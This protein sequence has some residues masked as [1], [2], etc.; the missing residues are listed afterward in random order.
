MGI[1]Q[2]LDVVISLAVVMLILATVVAAASQTILT[3][4]MVRARYMMDALEGLLS[5]SMLTKLLDDPRV[6]QQSKVWSLAKLV[7]RRFKGLSAAPPSDLRR[8]EVLTMLLEKVPSADLG[9]DG[10]KA[11][12]AFNQEVL[13]QE[14]TNPA[15]PASEWRTK[16]I[17]KLA[18]EKLDALT[19]GERE[20]FAALVGKVFNSF[21]NA[22]DRVADHTSMAGRRWALIVA[23]GV[24]FGLGVDTVDV[25]KRLSL[26]AEARAKL[27]DIATKGESEVKNQSDAILA[28]GQFQFA[29]D[30]APEQRR[31]W[32]PDPLELLLQRM[33]HY[34][35]FPGVW[36][37]W[38]L[39]S[40]GAPFWLE[41]IRKLAGF[42]DVITHKEEQARDKRDA[43]QRPGGDRPPEQ[44]RRRALQAGAGG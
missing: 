41:T 18:T 34:A 40:L 21:D 31:D 22:M 27:V 14:K 16:A 11:L 10:E 1:L 7:H 29:G 3:A 26:S 35:T 13:A 4:A 36:I 24:V 38:I 44:E 12:K 33:W 30:F 43:D 42:R 39:V 23:F 28:T 8:E 15:A 2:S 20:K 5:Q 37:T 6:G 32:I 17:L 25:A 9:F 19:D